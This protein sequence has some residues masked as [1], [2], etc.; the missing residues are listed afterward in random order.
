[1]LLKRAHNFAVMLFPRPAPRRNHNSIQ[2]TLPCSNNPRR[3]PAVRDDHRNASIRD[4]ARVDAVG[5][6]HEVRP[7][8][9]KKNAEGM[10][11][12]VDHL[13]LALDDPA[14]GVSLLPHALKHSLS[15]LEFRQ[16]NDQQHAQSHV[17][18]T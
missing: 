8:P 11:S 15:L 12:V 17:E 14:H 18:S 10:H 7:A 9:G 1:M 6:G 16:R 2:S 5:D 4:A 13:A 3:V